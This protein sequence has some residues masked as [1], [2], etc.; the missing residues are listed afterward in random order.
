MGLRTLRGTVAMARTSAPDS[1][2][3]QFFINHRSNGFLDS[4]GDRV[5]YAVFR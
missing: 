3:A 1:A 4:K 5:G 2:Q